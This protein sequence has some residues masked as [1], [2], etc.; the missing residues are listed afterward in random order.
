M[1]GNFLRKGN[2]LRRARA[3]VSRKGV[4]EDRSERRV[5]STAKQGRFYKTKTT[6][7]ATTA[8][9]ANSYQIVVLLV[10]RKPIKTWSPPISRQTRE[11]PPNVAMLLASSGTASRICY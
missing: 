8:L 5:S 11:V 1:K 9:L 4:G 2:L 7:F 3:C 10:A 6:I